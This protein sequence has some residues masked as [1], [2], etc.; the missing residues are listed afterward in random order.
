MSTGNVFSASNFMALRAYTEVD[1]PASTCYTCLL[2][3]LV[4]AHAQTHPN[5]SLHSTSYMVRWCWH[6]MNIHYPPLDNI[7]HVHC[8]VYVYM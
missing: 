7:L 6:L 3:L 2:S 5:D 1:C 8:N 4:A